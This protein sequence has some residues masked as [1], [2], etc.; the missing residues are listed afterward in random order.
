M[1]SHEEWR[2]SE[3]KK[4]A[5]SDAKKKKPMNMSM[6][7]NSETSWPFRAYTFPPSNN[8]TLENLEILAPAILSHHTSSSS[9][10]IFSLSLSLFSHT[11][12][13]FPSLFYFPTYLYPHNQHQTGVFVHSPFSFC[14]ILRHGH[15]WIHIS[16]AE[17]A[18]IEKALGK[19][20]GLK[21]KSQGAPG[22]LEMDMA[23]E[24]GGC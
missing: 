8:E 21:K 13:F 12:L 24:Y 16:P 15:G 1:D 4:P 3:E 9:L 17:L 7:Q 10:K 19:W 23:M 22:H 20:H 18:K 6:W 2:K 14:F 11:P 5:E